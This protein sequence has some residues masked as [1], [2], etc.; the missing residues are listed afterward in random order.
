MAKNNT[1]QSVLNKPFLITILAAVSVALIQWLLISF[2]I[3]TVT[4]MANSIATSFGGELTLLNDVMVVAVITVPAA[5]A[6]FYVLPKTTLTGKRA[7]QLLVATAGYAAIL[8]CGLLLLRAFPVANLNDVTT[9]G[10]IGSIFTNAT[11]SIV[12]F[13]LTIWLVRKL[14]P[15]G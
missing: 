4:D 9:G 5:I 2:L 15:R 7:S 6:L 3:V 10:E 1:P 11:V 12:A 13:T 14:D 8:V